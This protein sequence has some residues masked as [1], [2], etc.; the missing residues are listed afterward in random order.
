MF[1]AVETQPGVVWYGQLVL[2]FV[3]Q[4]TTKLELCYVRWLDTAANVASHYQRSLAAAEQCGPFRSFRWS[5]HAGPQWVCEQVNRGRGRG[6][7]PSRG[8]GQWRQFRG[9]PAAGQPHYGVVFSD[10]VRYRAPLDPSLHDALDSADPL[11]RLNTDKL[12]KY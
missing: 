3:A 11:Y 8:L 9:H 12:G 1:V 2:C 5:P 10:Q 6:Q 7:A 4:Y